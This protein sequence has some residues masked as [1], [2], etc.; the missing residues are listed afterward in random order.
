MSQ[1]ERTSCPTARKHLLT[2]IIERERVKELETE[3][4]KEREHGWNKP[5]QTPSKSLTRSSSS[6]N[7]RSQERPRMLSS[8]AGHTPP[9]ADSEQSFLSPH[10][11]TPGQPRRSLSRRSSTSSLHS[12]ASGNSRAPSPALSYT[13]AEPEEEREVEHERERNWNSPRPKWGEHHHGRSPSPL[14]ASAPAAKTAGP[15]PRERK[16][17]SVSLSYV[18]GRERTQSLRT[19][20]APTASRHI[21]TRT[22]SSIS[23]D[24]KGKTPLTAKSLVAPRASLGPPSRSP[25]PVRVQPDESQASD[26]RSRFGWTFPVNRTPLPPLELDTEPDS[27]AKPRAAASTATPSRMSLKS[28][29][30]SHIPRPSSALGEASAGKKRGHKRSITELSKPTGAIPPPATP[31]GAPGARKDEDGEDG[32]SEISIEIDTGSDPEPELEEEEESRF[33]SFHADSQMD[34][35]YGEPKCTQTKIGSNGMTASDEDSPPATSTPTARPVPLP[36]PSPWSLVSSASETP[37]TTPSSHPNDTHANDGT[38]S[39]APRPETPPQTPAETISAPIFSLQTP[40]RRSPGDG[41]SGNS[42]KLEFKTPSPPRGMPDLPDPPSF[43][44]DDGNPQSD[45]EGENDDNTPVMTSAPSNFTMMKTPRPPGAWAATPDVRRPEDSFPGKTAAVGD[46]SSASS[47][48]VNTPDGQAKVD[49]VAMAGATPGPGGSNATATWPRTPAP[50]GAWLQTP[51]GPASVRRRSILKV[52]FDVESETTVSDVGDS[53]NETKRPALP[54]AWN[55]NAE[56]DS[57]TEGALAMPPVPVSSQGED[58]KPARAET[59]KTPPPKADRPFRSPGSVSVRIVD[60]YGRETKPED[61]QPLRRAQESRK[62][63]PA[64]PKTP[65]RKT[66]QPTALQTP[67]SRSAVRIVDA[68]GREIEEPEPAASSSHELSVHVRD[69][70]MQS[71]SA[72]DDEGSSVISVDMPTP[73]THNEALELVRENVKTMKKEARQ[74][75]KWVFFFRPRVRFEPC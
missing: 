69:A 66:Q 75:E 53:S 55:P 7:L 2:D 11:L 10:S 58:R 13:D 52:R 49:V 43:S 54:A 32:D 50:P 12:A 21:R 9:R 62:D 5:K 28:P 40:P 71:I 17:S 27:P 73:T 41:S 61:E 14:P 45:G 31:P 44:T 60:A 68:M 29:A 33:P 22:Q 15:S 4:N 18:S 47:V 24:V 26:F 25:S 59:P 42:T 38:T 1:A 48:L 51:G 37:F 72:L 19:S 35:V 70:S 3:R 64:R 34:V 39:K 23:F 74:A 63:A 67:R 6:L 65:E 56:Q 20:P 8:V 36:P 30:A 46:G 57:S 16:D